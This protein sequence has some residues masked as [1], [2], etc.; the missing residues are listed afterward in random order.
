MKKIIGIFVLMLVFCLLCQS[1][2]FA[3]AENNYEKSC[4][5]LSNDSYNLQID[6]D[7]GN[8]IKVVN[9]SIDFN[10]IVEN[11]GANSCSYYEVVLEIYDHLFVASLLEELE[12]IYIFNDSENPLKENEKHDL[13]NIW[14]WIPTQKGIY[15]VR[16]IVFNESDWLHYDS[17]PF[18]VRD[19][20]NRNVQYKNNYISFFVFIFE[21]FPMLERLLG[22][23]R[24]G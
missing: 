12:P 16:A 11:H 22:L 4:Y 2:I 1:N 15:R 7:A 19:T 21:R 9:K 13:S 20:I 14:S 10:V 24:I 6:V 18:Y 8:Y 17:Q 23:I 3:L 5:M